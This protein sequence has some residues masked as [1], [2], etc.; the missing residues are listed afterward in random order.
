[1]NSRVTKFVREVIIN[2]NFPYYIIAVII[3]IAL[4]FLY[5]QST[6]NDLLFIL[7]P[8]DIL[9]SIITGT[10]SVYQPEAGFMH[11]QLNIVVGKSC[12]GINFM[13][14]SFIT[15]SFV[16]IRRPEKSIYKALVIPAT[17]IF[18]YIFTIFTNT[19]R[20][21]VSI[22]VQHLADT[23]YMVRPHELLHEATGIAINLSFLV[24]LFYFAE[25]SINKRKYNEKPA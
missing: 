13:L 8:T 16:T 2:R 21:V 22:H 19:C 4:K 24:L 6:N 10:Y 7:A 11:D 23:F 15:L 3:F 12:A 25:K 14:L 1:M 18:A 17:L 20:I 9:V 5:T